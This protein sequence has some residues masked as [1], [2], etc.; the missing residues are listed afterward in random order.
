MPVHYILI[1]I[2]IGNGIWLLLLFLS[3]IAS[4]LVHVGSIYPSL[5]GHQA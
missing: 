5:K 4:A 1:N 2:M 3:I